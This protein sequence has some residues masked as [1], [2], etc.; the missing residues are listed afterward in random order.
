[1]LYCAS[2]YYKSGSIEKVWLRTGRG[3]TLCRYETVGG[4]YASPLRISIIL[5]ADLVIGVPGPKMA[6]TPA[7]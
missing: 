5:I 1:M 3:A 2:G 4:G 7:L 6:A